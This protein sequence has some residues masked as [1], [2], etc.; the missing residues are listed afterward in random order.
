MSRTFARLDHARRLESVHSRH[1]NVEQYD[2]ELAL[3]QAAQRVLARLGAHESLPQRLEDGLERKQI[4]GAIV[5]EKDV[6]LLVGARHRISEW[7]SLA[8]GSVANV[9]AISS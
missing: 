7:R 2:G 6:D 1:L 3:E 9:S 4:L 8:T 5:D